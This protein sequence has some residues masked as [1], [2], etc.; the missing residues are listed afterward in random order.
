MIKRQIII[1]CFGDRRKQL[2]RIIENIRQYVDYPVKIITPKDSLIEI[3]SVL[4]STIE[5]K[6][7]ERRWPKGSPREGIR[8]SNFHKVNEAVTHHQ[9]DSVLMLDDDMLIVNNNFVDGFDIAER[10]GAAVPLNPR[11]F[12]KF[13]AM[14]ADVRGEDLMD[15][16]DK[17]QYAPAANFSPFFVY[18]W[19]SSGVR[20]F[21]INLDIQLRHKACRGTLA[22]FK[23]SWQTRFSPVYLPEQWCVSGDYAEHFKNYDMLLHGRWVEIPVMML[24]LGHKE[25]GRVFNV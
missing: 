3:P 18:Q 6:F 17:P 20:D 4:S 16:A 22:L 23:A 19:G 13:N 25:V 21:M 8:N 1:A 24:H 5:V 11:V 15:I 9:R 10:F 2:E 12:V 14:G 7:V